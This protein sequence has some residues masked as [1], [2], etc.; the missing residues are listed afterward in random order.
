MRKQS[1]Y[2]S[3]ISVVN[4][5]LT[6]TIVMV[7]GLLT[8]FVPQ[9]A[10]ATYVDESYNYS[11]SL[12]GSNKIRIQVP[13]YD[14][15]GA[16]CWVKNGKLYYQVKNAD[17]SYGSEVLVFRWY[18][19]EKSHDNDDKDLWCKHS[20]N[21]GGSFDV[22]QGNSGNHFTLTSSSGEMRRLIYES[23]ETYT[24]YAVWTVPYN[25]LGKTLRFKWDVL[26]D[27]TARSEENV[28]GLNDVTI[29]LPAAENINYPQLTMAT[30][31]F[32]EQGKLEIPWFIATNKLVKAQYQYR[33]DD[34]RYV[35]HS[36]S[37]DQSG[38]TIYL[39]ATVPHND[40]NVIVDYK[41][42]DDYLVPNV[43]SAVQNLEM[44]HAPINFRAVPIGGNKAAVKLVW[45][46]EYPTCKDIS[47][48]DVFEIQRSLTGEEADFVSIGAEPF[49]AGSLNYEYI[50]SLLIPAINQAHLKDGNSLDKLTYRIRRAVT[51]TWGWEGNSTAATSTC[52]VDNLHLIRIANYTAKWED[53]RAFTV[54]VSW[55]YAD[56]HGA[57]LDDRS[58]MK[59]RVTS[60]NSAGAPVDTIVYS[61]T[62]EEQQAR[63]KIV[64]LSRPCVDYKIEMFV[65]QGTSPIGTLDYMDFFR[66]SSNADWVT[67]KNMVT[68]ANGKE[69]NAML[70]ADIT[71]SEMVGTDDS[72]YV[73]TFDGNGHT[74]ECKINDGTFFAAPFRR[75]G[76]AT[77]RNLHI[78]GSVTSRS[79]YC[80]GLIGFVLANSTVNINGCRSSAAINCS[81]NG[82]AS[83]GG[84]VAQTSNNVNILIR[85]SLFDGSLEGESCSNNGG[86]VGFLNPNNTL[87]IEGCMFNPRKI[88]TKYDGCE[89]WARMSPSTTTLKVINSYYT[90]DYR[91]E[92]KGFFV[93]NSADDW[94]TFIKKVTD[95]NANSNVDAIL[96][97]DISV[98]KGTPTNIKYRGTFDGGGHTLYVD[99]DGGA[100]TY[101]AP[102]GRVTNVT[103]RNLHVTGTVDGGQH[104]SGLIGLVDGNPTVKIENVRVSVSVTS[105]ADHVGG[106]FG[107]TNDVQLTVT[108]C[109]FDGT[110]KATGESYGGAI[111]GWGHN[112]SWTMNRVYECGT[113]IDIKHASLCYWYN[114]NGDKSTNNWGYNGRSTNCISAQN[115]GEMASAD[116]R[117]VQDPNKVLKMMN[118][119]KDGSWVLL[120]DE[121]VPV[122]TSNDL[123][124]LKS[125]A[126]V[127]YAHYL[128][129]G[130]W[131]IVG[132]SVTIVPQC[133]VW[134]PLDMDV[135]PD[136][137][138]FHH[139]SIGKIEK[140]LKVEP[141]QSSVVLTWRTDDNPIDFFTVLRRVKDDKGDWEI[142]ASDLDQLGY[143]DKTVSPLLDYE[144][145]VRATNDCEG[146]SYTETEIKEG[147]CKHSGMVE[148]Y[149]RFN[150]GTGAPGIQ[151]EIV[152]ENKKN[153]TV[154]T[155][156]STGYFMADELSY[157][158]EPSVTY[159]LT[160]VSK[161]SMKLESGSYSVE[162]NDQSNFEKVKEFIITNGISFSAYVMYEGTSIPVKGAH[163][164]VNGNLM[165]NAQNGLLETDFEGRVQFTVLGDI[166][167][168]IQ[169]VMDDHKFTNDGY[170][171]SKD[172][173]VLTDKVSQVYFYDDT[174][175]K[176]TG[177]IVGGKDQG[178]LP[179]DN[180]LSKNNLG[181][182]LTMVMTLEGDNTSWLVY[183]NQNPQ[184]SKRNLT[185]DHPAGDGHKTTVELQR[186][187][188]IVKPDSVTGE[189]VLMLPPVRWKVMQIY[190]E[191]YP[192]L[193]Q[194]GMVSE[195][196]DLTECLKPRTETYKGTFVN[197]D[198][199]TVYQPQETYNARY[200]RI[201]HAPVEITYEQVGYDS[202][203]YFGDRFYQCQ[204][205][206]G[207]NVQV[208]L[209][210]PDSLGKG[211]PAHYTFGHPVFSVEHKYPVKL[212]VVE[213]YP[214]NND[215][216][217]KIVDL[218]KIGGGKVTIHNGMKSG[219]HQE[220]VELDSLGEGYFNLEA[221][222][223]TR[224]L[225]GENAL[226]TVTMT[227]EQDGTTYEA[228]PLK[229][230]ILNMFAT[231]NTRDII[232]KNRPLL[233]D[234]LR[235][236]P[237]SGSSATL[238]KGSKLKYNYTLD[239]KFSAGLSLSWIT[240]T[241]VDNYSGVVAG[242]AEY[243]I[244]NSADTHHK[245]D[246]AYI[247]NGE[248]KKA[249]SYTMSIGQD[250]TTSGSSTMVGAEADLYI[251]TVQNIVV[252][253]MSTIRA[254]PDS[255]YQHM[256]GRTSG[257]TMP[258][259]GNV[260][261]GTLVH[262]A[263]GTDGNGK[264]FHLI[265]DESLGYGPQVSSQFIH[266]QKHIVSELIPKLI[267]E[268]RS[269]IFTG[270]ADEAQA[271]ANATN[272]PVYRSL[273]SENDERFA[274]ANM[275]DGKPYY[276]TSTM[277]TEKGMNY[278][279]HLPNGSTTKFAD[280]VAEKSEIVMAWV[281]MIGE[282]EYEKLNAVEYVTNYDVDGAMKLN[283]SET[284]ESEYSQSNYMH[285]P[286]VVES[287]YWDTNGLG[288]RA[289]EGASMILSNTLTK[290]FIKSL[291][292]KLKK[293]PEAVGSEGTDQGGL[294]AKVAFMGTTFQFSIMPSLDYS[295][296]N[297]DTETKNFSRKESFNISMD[298]KSHLNFD[299]YRTV[300]LSEAVKAKGTFDVFTN[301]NYD[302][303]LKNVMSRLRDDFNLT[304]ARYPRGFVYRTRGGAT[305]NTWED[306][307]Y[308]QVY[309]PG[310]LIDERTKKI[311]NPKITLDRQSVSGVAIGDP[312]RFKVYLTN[313]SEQPEVATGG[314]T[315]FTLFVDEATNPNGAKIYVDGSAL[316][317]NGISVIL[318]PGKIVEKTVEVYAGSEFD[319]EGLT[320]GIASSSDFA[321]TQDKVK[322]D[323][324]Y[325]RQAGPVNI[326]TPGDKWVMNT[327]AEYNEKRGW[328]LPVTI[329]G[330]DKYQHNFDH[331]EFQYK[332]SQRGDEY[333]TNL[334]SYYADSTLMA[335]ANGVCEMIPE[336]GNI[337]TEFYGEGT[338]M[339]KAYDL[340]A[341]LYCRDGNSFLTTPS[342]VM[343][344]VKDTRRPQL[345]G[346]PEPKDGVLTFGNNII[347]N[348]SEDIEYNYL[349]DITNFEVKGEVNNDRVS[350]KVSIQFTGQSSVESDAQRNFSGK[351]VTIDVMIQPDSTGRNMPIF[352]HGTNNK[353]LQLWL[354]K[355]YHL[356][357]V[358]DEQTFTTDSVIDPAAF[359]QIA[360]VL[361]HPK[362]TTECDSLT[363]YN[364]GVQ[365]GRYVLKAPYV[366]AGPL[367]FGRTNETNRNKSQFYQGRMMEARLW[368][369]AMTGGQI[370]T[371]YGSKRLTG[372][373]MGLVDYYP[374]NE[375]SGEYALDKTQGANAKLI[376]ANWAMPRGFSLHLEKEDKGLTLSQNALNRTPEQ[377][378][379]LMFWFKTDSEGRGVLISNGAGRKEEIG[380]KNHFCLGFESEKLIYRTNGMAFEVPGNWSDNQWHH[381]VMTVN[382][383][384]GQ[385]NIYVD[386]TLR[387][388]FSADS[389]GGISGGHPLI[390]AA[391]YSEKQ[392]DGK[393][394]TI[395][396]RKWLRGNID[397][398]CLFAQALPLTLI[399]SY[400]TKSPN[401]DEA[402]LLTYLSFDRQERQ[403]DN[404]L[405][406]VPYVYSKKIYLDDKGNVRYELDPISKEYTSTPVRDYL[407]DDSINVIM[408]H[409][410][411]S[412]AAPVVPYEELKN[413]S[414]SFV[415]KDNQVLVGIDE[416]TSRINRR[417]IYVTV[418]GIEDKNGN[419]MASPA[420]ACYYVTNSTLQWLANRSTETV[421]YGQGEELFMSIVNVSSQ[422]H[423]Y[424]IENCPKWLLLNKTTDVIGPEDLAIIPCVVNKD[425]N[426]GTYDEIIYLTDENG[427][428]EPF[429]LNLRVEGKTPEWAE[430]VNRELLQYSMNIVGQVVINNEID[431][432]SH[433]IVGVFDADNI[434]HGYAN[435]VHSEQT[436]ESNLYLTVYDNM[437]SG[438]ELFFKL[439]QYS[440]G[441]ELE[442]TTTPTI[443]FEKSAV[444]G[445]EKPIRLVGGE[446]YYQTFDL[447]KGWNWVSFNVAS[448]DLLDPN[449][450][451]DRMPWK[452]NDVL[453][454]MNS[455]VT[456]MY[457]NGHWLASENLSKVRISPK[458]AYAIMVQEDVKFPIYGAIIKQENERTI[459]LKQGWNGIGYTP[460]MN[461]T[462][463]TAL[464]DYYDKAQ[465][466]DVI[467]SQEEFAYFI[468]TGGVGRWRGNLAYMKPGEGYML[469]RKSSSDASF[470]YPFYEPNSTFIDEWSYV[471]NRT[472]LRRSAKST[473]TVS[474]TVEG[475]ELE[476]GDHLVA[477]SDGECCGEAYLTSDLSPLF[478]LSI[479]GETHKKIWFAIERNGEIIAS[480]S[481]LM[482]FSTN[483]VVGSPD[484]PTIISF[485]HTD[486]EDGKWYT[487]SGVQLPSKPTN[488]GIYIYNGKKIIIK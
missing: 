228:T 466:G 324:H 411:G 294:V 426:V 152:S 259:D 416:L 129:D 305:C 174:K 167:N 476:E 82:E 302:D 126:E 367:I 16:D 229:G 162:F 389:L 455:D 306:A 192:T 242:P 365:I 240:G 299:V 20:T 394:A 403:K 70:T 146:V 304:K 80:S 134:Q 364:G 57:V 307:R 297:T 175:V 449:K 268:C 377:D 110:L 198:G 444:L 4:F 329:D 382:R 64:T 194:D 245:F 488:K 47:S 59:L 363:F 138:N 474:A 239:M 400:S 197:P 168:T 211:Y 379:T 441:R 375:G 343:S 118:T 19:D 424:T 193:F 321:L 422:T 376:Y 432:D 330:F 10:S 255:I 34:G 35:T 415:G 150:D 256:L 296:K 392:E 137:P 265:R 210:Y 293:K 291:W 170:Y 55:N 145:K 442:L 205:A 39:D 312:A 220:E 433:D 270:S 99:L 280:E 54:R 179:L 151:V 454:D 271:Q 209:V 356:K 414:F 326:S 319:Y 226:H 114:N 458:K 28:S 86:F 399:K 447:K 139:E 308:T 49:N 320:I 208:P 61:L 288:D 348:F 247:V 41:D 390:G 323:V 90:T 470:V 160:P 237:G 339:E 301:A 279:I 340:R 366:G 258:I 462:V 289:F 172:G 122:L 27:G 22:T 281:Q 435:I 1:I 282:N 372:Y 207:A 223:T 38:G 7:I 352:S 89:T 333:W 369:R 430:S 464:S 166:S 471:S 483:A 56:E 451:L 341:V 248:G 109:L 391:L 156:D 351:D 95:A 5:R 92:H 169:V 17:G 331:I 230:Y 327:D 159:I 318:N 31:S 277:A 85:N 83:I 408:N 354:T 132:D 335:Q 100:N 140:T 236:P 44:V 465:P 15:R 158:G 443:K 189:Y 37:A 18:Q 314:L 153:K 135:N 448:E 67:F 250:I 9:Q 298:A 487:V 370:G 337:H 257:G 486:N 136:L 232:S 360:M 120:H 98:E 428:S 133:E 472:P 50:D 26:R 457:L 101:T 23:A 102:F 262:I 58:E 397:E 285:I 188:M 180:N 380:A 115:W 317:G 275:K 130:T 69:V 241:T 81:Y 155:T 171:K 201:Y 482:T 24:I 148:G 290:N 185:F 478:Y 357:A 383:S 74:L 233:I 452:E 131:K 264:L 459:D 60:T 413:L 181:D 358:V 121:A 177:R 182:D 203:S 453:T 234:I 421:M 467:K 14:E 485:V 6:F 253:P 355:D 119:E 373:E 48:S 388:T 404:N 117:N 157:Q 219:L 480:T 313:E 30:I 386:Q 325:L 106:F 278:V 396:T 65:E 164:K 91:S 178:D 436:G 217:S 395:D 231:G 378:Y 12:N 196:I 249:Y 72:P 406:L 235:D 199:R 315:V 11:V 368:Y 87:T 439:W 238:S 434:C 419:A 276:Y 161:G 154:V 309:K 463:E 105:T 347:F 163:F 300:T 63:F 316:N 342:K 93:I 384:R 62:Q 111:C 427:V 374:M 224:L 96:G 45:Q 359:T 29:T 287:D 362:D 147:A 246:F 345:F 218:V 469:L 42:K 202:I 267:N 53:E 200:N 417:N 450:L 292:D 460:M 173:V 68:A 52:M 127:G 183:D 409:I 272:K 215:P 263:K 97:T 446:N 128:L 479:G 387:T 286:F 186:K 123:I 66:I 266:S 76:N 206:G 88:T 71:I 73:G 346:T 141:R 33:S 484:E 13:V 214:W 116:H 398:L 107:H 222:Q 104:A 338:V 445:T 187:R 84:F 322:L 75:V 143:E 344:G 43:P 429:Y 165:H 274:V 40:F 46:T 36:L 353:T 108:D 440:T 407:F 8:W 213:R 303:A 21:A 260:K 113:Y 420:T 336:N 437:K 418:R 438:R 273:V 77:F 461:L 349:N 361:S 254:I 195:V 468:V 284:F 144:Y 25:L 385:V 371:T 125:K 332:E 412:M 295:C 328:F 311:T 149:V 204:T 425:L 51:Q 2:D 475:V 252:T 243:G 78:A 3:I 190:C 251:G 112:G 283:Y 94:N 124:G 393:V 481:E 32:S 431:I 184:L 191:G 401:G 350:D 269:M 212:A 456:L 477:Y 216:Y 473:M 310:T 225:T 227:L 334:C 244:I 142:V 405:E 103:I 79:K 176:L 261:Y 381:Y 423:T 410:D 221:D 402:G